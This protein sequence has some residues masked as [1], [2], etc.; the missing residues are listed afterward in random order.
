MRKNNHTNSQTR[1]NKNEWL[2]RS[3][4]DCLTATGLV[5]RI[6]DAVSTHWGNG[7][8]C[9]HHISQTCIQDMILQ[10]LQHGLNTTGHFVHQR[11]HEV[12]LCGNTPT[13]EQT[14]FDYI[15]TYW[16]EVPVYGALKPKW[17][18]PSI[19]DAIYKNVGF[20]F[21]YNSC[22]LLCLFTV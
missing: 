2:P 7:L 11:E 4:S 6:H 13:A 5:Y 12:Q 16:N 3:F 22:M 20:P 10:V 8:R 18:K 14:H 9:G 15:K 1:I 19:P 17:F 21:T